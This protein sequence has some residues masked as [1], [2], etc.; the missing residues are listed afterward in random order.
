MSLRKVW[1]NEILIRLTE[2]GFVETMRRFGRE[3]S[4]AYDVPETGS[5]E[6]RTK[7]GLVPVL[8]KRDEYRRSIG[9]RTPDGDLGRS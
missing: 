6:Q 8:V 5:A 7:G 9:Y 1:E 2:T 4:S 3:N